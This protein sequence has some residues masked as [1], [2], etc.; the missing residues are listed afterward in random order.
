MREEEVKDYH[1]FPQKNTLKE[2]GLA[3][4]NHGITCSENCLPAI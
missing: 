3:K 1:T 2:D 4:K